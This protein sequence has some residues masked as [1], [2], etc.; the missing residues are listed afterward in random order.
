MEG[1]DPRILAL[2]FASVWFVQ[3]GVDLVKQ[4][5]GP[6]KHS[7]KVLPLIGILVAWI[8]IGAQQVYQRVEP[9][10]DNVAGVLL[11][12]IVAQYLAGVAATSN[13]AV[14]E[15]LRQQRV[16]KVRAAWEGAA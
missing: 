12:G 1:I 16:Q 15:K 5:I 2:A 10:A 3:I 13:K 14:S 7:A 8:V 11:A 9:T 6:T 4:A